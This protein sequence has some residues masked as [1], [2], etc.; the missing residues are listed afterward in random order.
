MTHTD[1]PATS[2]GDGIAA[3]SDASARADARAGPSATSRDA[4]SVT[5][6]GDASVA[7]APTSVTAAALKNWSAPCGR[8]SCGIPAAAAPSVVPLPPWWTTSTGGDRT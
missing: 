1:G 2:A 4:A 3:I 6:S 7:P 5:P 8:K